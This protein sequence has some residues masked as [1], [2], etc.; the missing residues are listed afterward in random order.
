MPDVL[1]GE[2]RLDIL[3]SDDGFR[4]RRQDRPEPVAFS[5]IG[6]DEMDPRAMGVIRT[7]G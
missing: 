3:E 5:G 2:K 6:L 7:A 1:L 4:F